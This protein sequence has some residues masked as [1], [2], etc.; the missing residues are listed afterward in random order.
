[1]TDYLLSVF[2]HLFIRVGA[3]LAHLKLW[4]IMA[5]INLVLPADCIMSETLVVIIGKIKNSKR[6]K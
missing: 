1:M 4:D 3:F 5:L 2:R 6:I